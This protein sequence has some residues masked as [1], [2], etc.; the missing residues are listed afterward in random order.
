[1]PG[2]GSRDSKSRDRMAASTQ[3]F[4]VRERDVDMSLEKDV[5]LPHGR[6]G[7]DLPDY[8]ESIDDLAHS[9]GC[10]V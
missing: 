6:K 3:T 4:L 10:S 5:P 7:R 1:M 2:G 8:P 9:S